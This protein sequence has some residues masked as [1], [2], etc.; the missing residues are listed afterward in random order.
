[1]GVAVGNAHASER[2]RKCF[3]TIALSRRCPPGFLPGERWDSGGL[4]GETDGSH[5]AIVQGK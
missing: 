4:V 5:V 3:D 2:M 1:M